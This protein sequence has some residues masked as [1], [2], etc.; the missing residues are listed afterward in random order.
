M[1]TNSIRNQIRFF[2]EASNQCPSTPLATAPTF[3]SPRSCKA[4]FSEG[5]RFRGAALHRPPGPP[6]LSPAPRKPPGTRS[7]FRGESDG[8]CLAAPPG[9]EPAKGR[10]SAEA[11]RGAFAG[12]SPRGQAAAG[13]WCP[14]PTRAVMRLRT[15]RGPR[16]GG[17]PG[18]FL[19]YC[20]AGSAT[21]RASISAAVWA[22][23][24][25]C[26]RER[27]V[28]STFHPGEGARSWAPGEG[29]RSCKSQTPRLGEEVGTRFPASLP[30]PCP[31][32]SG[33]SLLPRL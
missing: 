13:F 21:K 18:W 17:K 25:F 22:N 15:H 28:Y 6:L 2:K 31:G 23:D 24:G 11:V 33:L 30:G 8:V 16:G 4:A 10:L 19:S 29:R 1:K 9:Q 12:C 26:W 3:F 5:L 20:R 14:S 27:G 7:G 32:G